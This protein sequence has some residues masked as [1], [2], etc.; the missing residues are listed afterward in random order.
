MKVYPSISETLLESVLD[1]T[2]NDVTIADDDHDITLQAKKS[3]FLNN[4]NPWEKR[5]TDTLFDVPIDSYDKAETCKLVG[6][7]ILL[8]LEEIPYSM[9]IGHYRDDGLAV[10][11]QTE[12]S[13]LFK[14]MGVD[15]T[16]PHDHRKSK[17]E[18]GKAYIVIFTCAVLQAVHL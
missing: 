18:E 12:V 7:Y 17:N 4:R 16:G 8:Q 15:F 6:M 3:L 9:D 1:F 11:D 14:N 10:V 13:R 5:N 2:A